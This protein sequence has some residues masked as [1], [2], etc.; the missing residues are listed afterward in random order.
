MTRAGLL[1][2]LLL[3]C[4]TAFRHPPGALRF[5]ELANNHAS[6]GEYGLA[7]DCYAQAITMEPENPTHLTTR[8]FFLLQLNRYEEALQDFTAVIR[9][10]PGKPGGYLT[11]GLV[12]SDLK[13]DREAAA[14]FAAACRLGSRDG[15]SFA[16]SR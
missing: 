5:I 13:R 7:L 10:A 6:S 1:L 4:L 2:C 12:Y 9:L 11:R 8:G 14:D 15:C 3:P 16:G